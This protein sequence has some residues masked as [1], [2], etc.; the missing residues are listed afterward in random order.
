MLALDG[1]AGEGGGQLLRS[2]LAVS[3]ATG[4]AFRISRIRASRDPP[5]LRSQHLTAARAAAEVCEA[6]LD[7]DRLGSEELEFRP[8]SLRPGRYRFDTGG[9]GSAVLVLQTVLPPLLSTDAESVVEVQGGTHNPMAPPYDFL[10]RTL[11]PFLNRRAVRVETELLRPGFYPAGGGRIRARVQ[12]GPAP[13][14]LE[15][16]DRAPILHRRVRALV[17]DLPRHIGEREVSTAHA[18]LDLRP[19]AMEVREVA[20]P[21][22]PG[23]VVMIEVEMATHT[24]VFTGFGRRGVPAEEVAMEACREADA[25]LRSDAPVGRHLA[26]QLLVPLALEGGGVYRT[27]GLT[28][29]TRTNAALLRASLGIGID[30]EDADDD[31]TVRIQP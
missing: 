22:G 5:G 2:A 10:E 20:D 16:T 3:A 31:S 15:L 4:R 13:P 28:S 6:T 21:R 24:E 9:A 18:F 27:T 30:L 7:G 29:H 25:Y 12:P 11:L 14:P 19:E 8:G 26:D 23:N 1:S 17:S